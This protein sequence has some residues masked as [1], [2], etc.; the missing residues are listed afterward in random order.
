MATF[1]NMLVRLGVVADTDKGIGKAVRDLDKVAD[2]ADRA[3]RSFRSLNNMFGSL[4]SGFGTFGGMLGS[5]GQAAQ[6]VTSRIASFTGSLASA[7]VSLITAAAKMAVLSAAMATASSGALGLV[8]ALAPAGGILTALPGAIALGVAALGV[9]KIALSGVGEA[10]GAALGDDYEAFL[11]AVSK[12]SPAASAAAF[13]LNNLKN[14]IDALKRSVQDAFFAPL[15]GQLTA[16]ADM[17]TRVKVADDVLRLAGAFGDAARQVAEFAASSRAMH[18]LTAIL[19]STTGLVKGLTPG[20]QPLLLGF[21]RL[22][23]VGARF[24]ADMGP[25]MGQLAARFGDFLTA[26]VESGRAWGWMNNALA[27]IKQLGAIL[28]D[29]GGIVKAV[30]TAMETAGGGALGVIGQLLD[31]MNKWINSAKGQDVLVAVFTA[32]N[33]IGAAF[34]PVI[35]ALASGIGTLAPVIAQLAT[36]IGPI[37]AGAINAVAPALAALGPGLLTVFGALGQAVKVLAPSLVPLGEALSAIMAAAAPLI[38]IVAQ[39][40]VTIAIALAG[41]LQ[42]LMPYLVEAVRALGPG[43]TA[44][45][46][47]VGQ[48]VAA[49]APALI[50]LAKAFSDVL[51]AVAPLLPLIA[52]LAADAIER[53]APV[54]PGLA[55]AFVK[56]LEALGPLLPVLAEVAAVVAVELTRAIEKIAP[57]LPDLVKS[58]GDLLIAL[59]PLIPEILNLVIELSPLIPVVTDVIKLLTR[60]VD[61][62]MPKIVNGLRLMSDTIGEKVAEFKKWWDGFYKDAEHAISQVG[63]KMEDFGR[64]LNDLGVKVGKFKDSA[65]QKFNDFVSWVK[66]LPEAISS[67]VGNVGSTL[68]NAGRDLITGFWNGMAG[69]FNDLKNRIQGFFSQIMPDWVK[70]ALGISSPS[71][72]FAELGKFIPAG[73][74]LGIDSA[75]NLVSDAA[76]RMADLA[77][78]SVQPT[79]SLAGGPSTGPAPMP[80]L[81]GVAA[82]VA[83][84]TSRGGQAMAAGDLVVNL[85]VNGADWNFRNSSVAARQLLKEIREGLRQLDRETAS[86]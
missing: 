85:T 18:S 37:L 13:E 64:W 38:P 65:I 14:P 46:Q 26:A 20:I 31:G 23:A 70:D 56:I 57:Y 11:L 66:G 40:A 82:P 55:A 49:L 5:L 33:Q 35:R 30:F 34:L 75:S 17:F 7:G 19:N 73:M 36:A 62:V 27:V 61:E 3:E 32:L 44:V 4:N 63:E 22:A 58:F 15:Q 50:P 81:S 25:G 48:A 12:L 79:L 86:V 24:I 59:V 72:L 39:F 16:I 29:L 69:Q 21:T 78:I 68:W 1:K 60:F 80:A 83:T 76:R 6:Q 28:A 47:A 42:T 52:K 43:L 77:T 54:L 9:L 84:G 2:R 8:S 74:A 53:L 71:K 51:I 10:F 41:A 45:I 67:A